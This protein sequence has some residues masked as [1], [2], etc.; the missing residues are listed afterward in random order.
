MCIL[1]EKNDD[2]E[3]GWTYHGQTEW[4]ENNQSPKFS[5]ALELPYPT[6]ETVLRFTILDVDDKRNIPTSYDPR[7]GNADLL[8]IVYL[9]GSKLIQAAETK[10]PLT[11]EMT[12]NK[13]K[14]EQPK[15]TLNVA[16][17]HDTERSCLIFQTRSA[18]CHIGRKHVL[19]FAS[20]RVR[21]L[22]AAN[23]KRAIKLAERD[24][25]MVNGLL[26]SYQESVRQFYENGYVQG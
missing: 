26:L 17:V 14:Q 11:L 20:E 12:Q 15:I 4:I 18:G 8:A 19:L 3:G 5:V 25:A 6:S 10:C 24:K 13:A 9:D 23:L 2:D 22:W 1:E 16:T 21:N 7:S